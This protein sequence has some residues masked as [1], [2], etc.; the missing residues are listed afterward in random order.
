MIAGSYGRLCLAL[1]ETE[2]LSFKVAV[3]LAYSE[4]FLVLISNWYLVFWILVIL[5]GVCWY[6]V[7]V[8]H[9]IYLMTNYLRVF[10]FVDHQEFVCFFFF[11][12]FAHLKIELFIL[13]FSLKNSSYIWDRSFFS[14]IWFAN[15][16]P[17]LMLCLFILLKVPFTEQKF[18]ILM[19][20]L[21]S[22]FSC[23][24]FTWWI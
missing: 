10:S 2:K 13:L 11:K 7:A 6:F 15:T 1:W 20:F 19:E 21:L 8:L 24:Y 18:L 23:M 4:F 14:D 22:V 5:I 3:S 17:Q 12:S 16:F 9:F